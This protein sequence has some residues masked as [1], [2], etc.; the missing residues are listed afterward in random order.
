MNFQESLKTELF[1]IQPQNKD[2]VMSEFIGLI[3]TGAVIKN[4]PTSFFY[5]SPAAIQL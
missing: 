2:E 5:F 1:T 3:R 4:I